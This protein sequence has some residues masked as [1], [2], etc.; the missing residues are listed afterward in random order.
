MC[1]DT[2]DAVRA[3]ARIA[4][5][6]IVLYEP[7]RNNPAMFLFGVLKSAERMSLRF[8]RRYMVNLSRSAG[9]E[10]KRHRVECTVLPN[11]TPP[12]LLWLAKFF[13][14]RPLSRLGFYT[15]V[16]ATPCGDPASGERAAL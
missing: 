2:L 1:F 9:L 16:A 13:D 3:F 4:R 14:R 11:R 6:W 7:N 12:S 5:R 10:V 8:S 15:M